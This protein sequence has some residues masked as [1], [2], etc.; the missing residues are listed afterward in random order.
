[1]DADQRDG[2]QDYAA[3]NDEE[4]QD[5]QNEQDPVLPVEQHPAN[6]ENQNDRNEANAERNIER[7]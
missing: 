3:N 4:Q 7:D 2:V 5:A 1:M 6:V